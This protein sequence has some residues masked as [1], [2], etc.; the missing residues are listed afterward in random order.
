MDGQLFFRIDP[1]TKPLDKVIK[2]VQYHISYFFDK[3]YVFMQVVKE[4]ST[5][6]N[7]ISGT[8]KS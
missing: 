7:I 6:M 2:E 3:G 1:N 5:N 4:Y 8:K